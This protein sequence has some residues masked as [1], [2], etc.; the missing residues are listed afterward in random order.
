VGVR[1]RRTTARCG[2]QFAVRHR[3]PANLVHLVHRVRHVPLHPAPGA[4]PTTAPIWVNTQLEAFGGGKDQACLLFSSY[5]KKTPRGLWRSGHHDI[6]SHNHI[7]HLLLRCMHVDYI[8]RLHTTAPPRRRAPAG[9][10][11]PARAAAALGVVSACVCVVRVRCGVAVPCCVLCAVCC[12]AG[13]IHTTAMD[14][15]DTI[16]D[17]PTPRCGEGP[18]ETSQARDKRQAHQRSGAPRPAPRAPP[19]DIL[20]TVWKREKRRRPNPRIANSFT[21]YHPR[22]QR[23]RLGA[24]LK[25]AHVAWRV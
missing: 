20:S 11:P 9:A 7:F 22:P 13:H 23:V 25:E 12:C 10:R 24:S 21:S 8:C 18:S 15:N 3:A 2:G 16:S 4:R 1:T 14:N 19:Q 17:T 5:Q 6:A